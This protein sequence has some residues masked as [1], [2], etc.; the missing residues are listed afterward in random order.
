MI[1]TTNRNQFLVDSTGNR[2][3]VPLEVGA[4]FQVPWK[5]L[6]EKR[7]S[8]WSAAVAAFKR[9]DTYE[10]DSGEIAAIA[11][12]IQ[13]FGDPDPWM[14]K[15]GAYIATREEVTT[16][17]VLTAALDLDPR[18]QGRRESRRVADVL[19]TMG[20]RRHSTSRKDPIT[21]KSKS[22]RLWLRPKDD[23]LTEDHILNDF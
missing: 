11:E 15:V 20:W 16:A 2:R 4:G 14:D 17:E 13:E 9:G 18:Q 12:Y 1:G 22:V 3:F 5:L 21:G 23:P 8:I 10:F 6:A 7:D 19:Q